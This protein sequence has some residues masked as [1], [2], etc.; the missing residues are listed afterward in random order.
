M[1]E[2]DVWKKPG[3][4]GLYGPDHKEE[5]LGVFLQIALGLDALG[6]VGAYRERYYM[7]YVADDGYVGRIETGY[8]YLK[9]Q[10]KEY[11]E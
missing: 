4:H 9:P 8:G 10:I 11:A 5:R 6:A 1:K 7:F 3:R 2:Y